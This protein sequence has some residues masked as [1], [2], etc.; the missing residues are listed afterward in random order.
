MPIGTRSLSSVPIECLPT[1]VINEVT[2]NRIAP[3]IMIAGEGPQALEYLRRSGPNALDS[4]AVIFLDLDMPN[5]N[6]L[7]VLRDLCE[8]AGA[9]RIPIDVFTGSSAGS[10]IHLS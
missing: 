6:G 4:P 10:D 8:K 3:H 1:I 9:K 5:V 2:N 7:Q